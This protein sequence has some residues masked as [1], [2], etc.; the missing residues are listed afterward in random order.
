MAKL[1][2]Q[3]ADRLE[4]E[5]F[6]NSTEKAQLRISKILAIVFVAA[7][8]FACLWAAVSQVSPDNVARHC[9]GTWRR[10]NADMLIGGRVGQECRRTR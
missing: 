8:V 9:L 3:W 2:S 5:G 6:S 4:E 10:K 7:H 1:Y